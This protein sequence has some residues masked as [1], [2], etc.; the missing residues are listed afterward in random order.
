MIEHSKA[1]LKHLKTIGGESPAFMEAFQAL[2]AAAFAD[3]AIDRKTKEL[4]AMS[5]GVAKQCVYCI[6]IHTAEAR[7]AGASEQEIAEAIGVATAIGAGATITHG[8]HAF[9]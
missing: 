8:T 5:V 9:G 6:D 3:G 7:K 4:I 2:N 1:N